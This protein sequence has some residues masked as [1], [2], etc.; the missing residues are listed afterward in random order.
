MVAVVCFFEFKVSLPFFLRIF[1]CEIIEIYREAG[2]EKK[3]SPGS[4]TGIR[5]LAE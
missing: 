4:P 5:H 3:M 2:F 1:Q